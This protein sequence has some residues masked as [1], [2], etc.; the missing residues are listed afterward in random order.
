MLR[1]SE[2]AGSDDHARWLHVSALNPV[3]TRLTRPH[4]PTDSLQ[5]RLLDRGYGIAIMNESVSAV[6]EPSAWAMMLIGFATASYRRSSKP[7]FRFV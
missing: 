1:R 6:P 7:G 4:P 3:G 2:F 5:S